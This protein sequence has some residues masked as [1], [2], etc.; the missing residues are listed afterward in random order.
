MY[1]KSELSKSHSAKTTGAR[2]LI[3]WRHAYLTKDFLKQ[4][5]RDQQSE[6]LVK[7]TWKDTQKCG[8]SWNIL[9]TNVH[10]TVVKVSIHCRVANM[11]NCPLS[12]RCFFCCIFAQIQTL[13]PCDT[14]MKQCDWPMLDGR[15][16]S[17]HKHQ[18]CVI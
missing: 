17:M 6:I 5:I 12:L 8:S 15:Y 13:D 2:T 14:M 4:K 10:M 9:R 18:I 7:F 16:I 11:V 1:Q 3:F